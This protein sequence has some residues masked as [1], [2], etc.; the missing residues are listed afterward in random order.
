MDELIE[1]RSPEWGNIKHAKQWRSTLERYADSLMG[2]NVE[3]ISVRDVVAVLR[4]IWL[5]KPETAKR[6]AQRIRAV[7]EYAEALEYETR[8]SAAMHKLSKLLPKQNVVVKHH[9]AVPLLEAQDAFKA[10]WDRRDSGQGARA[11]AYAILA[12]ARSGEA[13]RLRWDWI[14]ADRISMPIGS[15][16]RKQVAHDI[17]FTAPMQ[18]LLANAPRFGDC[19][20]VFPSGNRTEIS[21][22]TLAAV[23]KRIGINATPHGWRSVFIEWAKTEG[24]DTEVREDALHHAYKDSVRSAYERTSHFD[25]RI[26]VMARWSEWLLA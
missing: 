1:T 4:P 9:A 19:E 13:R 18:E 16:K 11:L 8:N 12:C 17:P 26:D 15:M 23:H 7:T 14:M 25:A 2:I 24:I 21:D 20:L 6:V 10:I 5:T 3:D 22:M